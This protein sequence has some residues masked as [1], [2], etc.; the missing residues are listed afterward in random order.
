MLTVSAEELLQDIDE[1]TKMKHAESTLQQ[2][3]R[4]IID[5]LSV[6]PMIP[7]A[8]KSIPPSDDSIVLYL[9]YRKKNGCSFNTIKNSQVA[10]SYY[11]VSNNYQDATKSKKVTDYISG[12]GNEMMKG[13]KPSEVSALK[14]E[15]LSE[16]RKK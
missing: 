12:L 1:T 5:Y 10:L 6:I 15:T 9:A 2:Y 4:I 13:Y 8:P 11:C 16:I 3:Q 14:P 7:G